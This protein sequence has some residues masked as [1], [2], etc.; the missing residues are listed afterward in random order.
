MFWLESYVYLVIRT[1]AKPET[2]LRQTFYE[3]INF[4]QHVVFVRQEEV[5]ICAQPHNMCR[6]KSALKGV[7]YRAK[8]CCFICFDLGTLCFR[9]L[10]EGITEIMRN[11]V[12]REN[13]DPNVREL[14]LPRANCLRNGRLSMGTGDMTVRRGFK[15]CRSS[16]SG[17]STPWFRIRHE[18]TL[19]KFAKSEGVGGAG[20]I[21]S[22]T[23]FCNASSSG[24][25]S[26]EAG[27]WYA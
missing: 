25:R 22:S 3:G 21:N 4:A 27:F 26:L 1:I 6:W 24:A 15:G 16:A 23:L 18:R 2:L 19:E 20:G 12:K 13:R 5:V 17:T 14:L 8:R 10:V 9:K 7:G 11:R